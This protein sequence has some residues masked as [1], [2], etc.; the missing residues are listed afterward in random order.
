MRSLLLAL[1]AFAALGLSVDTHEARAQ[2]PRTNNKNT[3]TNIN[4][5][6]PNLG[7]PYT[8]MRAARSMLYRGNRGRYR[9]RRSAAGSRPLII[10]NFYGGAPGAGPY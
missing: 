9:S 10:N 8:D 5:L 7:V 3:N 6:M 2:A 4:P 1:S